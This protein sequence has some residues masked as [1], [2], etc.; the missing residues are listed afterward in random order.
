[1]NARGVGSFNEVSNGTSVYDTNHTFAVSNIATLTP[2]IYNETRGQ[3]IYDNLYAPDND[4]LGPQ[5]TISGIATFGKFTGSPTGR[6]NY[7]GEVVDN[8]LIQRG[9]HTFKAGA[10]FIIQ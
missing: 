1:M 7:L 4:Q 10:D 2:H 5:V 3:F 8:L 9:A 6:K